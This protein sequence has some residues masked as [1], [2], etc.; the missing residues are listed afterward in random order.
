[1]DDMMKIARYMPAAYTFENELVT[2]LEFWVVFIEIEIP[3]N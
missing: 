3:S 1:M 2:I